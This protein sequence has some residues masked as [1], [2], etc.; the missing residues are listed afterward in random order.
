[1][2]GLGLFA[3][4]VGIG[5]LF[6]WLS[7]MFTITLFNN[8]LIHC[9]ILGFVFGIT[10]FLFVNWYFYKHKK[11]VDQN[12]K[13]KNRLVTDNLTGLFNRRALDIEL[14][15]L[16]LIN[17]SVIFID[18]DNFRVFNNQHG[19]KIGDTVLHKVSEVIKTTIRVGDRA[20]RY[21][22]E[23]IVIILRDCNQENGHRIAEK[24]RTQVSLLRNDPYPQ[25]TISLGV[26]SSGDS[27]SIE[28][29]IERADSAL[30]EAKASGKNRTF[31]SNPRNHFS[32]SN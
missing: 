8:L 18:I 28:D 21:G 30:L 17:Y 16:N 3:G 9:I 15:D 23:E 12:E 1:M 4:M 31:V 10:N 11:L 22:G 24:I 13:L 32:V 6:V 25:I 7:H 29:V 19:H 2:F 14:G 26:A 20:Y 27:E 5:I